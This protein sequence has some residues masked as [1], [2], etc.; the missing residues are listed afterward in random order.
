MVPILF[1][2]R[3]VWSARKKRGGLVEEKGCLLGKM[4]GLLRERGCLL[5]ERGVC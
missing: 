3:E 2:R 1:A 4:N 5:G